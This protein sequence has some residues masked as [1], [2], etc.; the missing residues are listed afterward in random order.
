[1]QTEV[2]KREEFVNCD[3][4]FPVI[5][6]EDENG[7]LVIEDLRELNSLLVVGQVGTPRVP[8]NYALICGI[9]QKCSPEE[10]KMLLI[11]FYGAEIGGFGRFPH[12][13]FNLPNFDIDG[14]IT[15]DYDKCLYA[16]DRLAKEAVYR[17][18]KIKELGA[19]NIEEY[20][21]KAKE[22]MP[23][24]VCVVE[25][26]HLIKKKD[27]GAVEGFIN[28]ITRFSKES[29]ICSP[30]TKS[31]T[32]RICAK[33]FIHLSSNKFH[34]IAKL[35]KKYRFRLKV[36]DDSLQC[37]KSIKFSKVSFSIFCIY[38]SFPMMSFS[39]SSKPLNF[40]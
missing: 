28:Q 23:Y 19:Q 24:I 1:M 39:I 35:N 11:D 4:K 12:A 27:I 10:V 37:K 13:K 8:F 15:Y 40:A 38:F 36:S 17:Y 22:K 3:K 18:H 21:K 32:L 20:N 5:V 7:K 31:S 30:S 2:L 9:A 25:Y 29:G 33:L 6:G 34:R 14:A 26:P 16:L